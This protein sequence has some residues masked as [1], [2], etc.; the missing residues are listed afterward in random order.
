[1]QQEKKRSCPECKGPLKPGHTE[2]VYELKEITITIKNVPA[3]IC[4]KCGQAFISGHVAEDVNRLVNRVR[5]DV[6]S[7]AKTQPGTAK[8]HKEVAIAV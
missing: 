7:F 2:M 3:D 8:R 6:N 1:M 4:T 5:E